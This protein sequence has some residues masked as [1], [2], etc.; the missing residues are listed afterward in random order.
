M[1]RWIIKRTRACLSTPS[2]LCCLLDQK[3]CFG[4]WSLVD[5]LCK[6]GVGHLHEARDIGSLDVVDVTVGLCTI[7]HTL[8]VDRATVAAT[9]LPTCVADSLRLQMT[10]L[11]DL[12]QEREITP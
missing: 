7:L 10:V 5:T 9:C 11:P 3:R 2:F 12:K 4:F 1:F 8:L 6:H